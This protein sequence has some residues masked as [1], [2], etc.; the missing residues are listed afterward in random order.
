MGEEGGRDR[1]D[2][3]DGDRGEKAVRRRDSEAR[4]EAAEPPV[5]QGAAQA[6]KAQGTHGSGHKEAAR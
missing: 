3:G 2:P 1:L 6:E 5:G 4:H